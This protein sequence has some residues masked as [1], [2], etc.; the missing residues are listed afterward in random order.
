MRITHDRA[1]RVMQQVHEEAEAKRSIALRPIQP[2]V[3]K[4]GPV[5]AGK[6]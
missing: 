3:E 5:T 2:Q 1:M 6:G 4:Q